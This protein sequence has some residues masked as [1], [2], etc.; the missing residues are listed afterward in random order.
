MD[1]KLILFLFTSAVLVG[2]FLGNYQSKKYKDV[3]SMLIEADKVLASGTNDSV[4]LANASDLINKVVEIESDHPKALMIK[5]LLLQ[6]R[7]L[8]KEALDV[9]EKLNKSSE[10][11]LQYGRFNAGVLYHLQKNLPLAEFNYRTAITYNPPMPM[12]W[13]N[14]LSILIE[15]GK[16]EEASDIYL[17]AIDQFPNSAEIKEYES[18]INK[19][20]LK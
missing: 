1:K 7:G 9:Y 8:T 5:A 12:F 13:T 17:E 3:T 19:I 15:Q 2:S 11:I 6:R 14:L 18:K 10:N 16:I 4:K 20:K